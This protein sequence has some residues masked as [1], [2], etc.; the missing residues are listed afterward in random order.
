MPRD[1]H[2]LDF[3]PYAGLVGTLAEESQIQDIGT[4]LG[5]EQSVFD[6]IRRSADDH[7]AIDIDKPGQDEYWNN[8]TAADA[9]GYIRDIVYGGL[10]GLAYVRS[11]AEFVSPPEV[12]V[13]F[14]VSSQSFY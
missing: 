14:F 1:A 3:G 9:Q 10:E 7:A 11:L 5:S 2:A 6:A 13:E 12:S 4:N 8:K